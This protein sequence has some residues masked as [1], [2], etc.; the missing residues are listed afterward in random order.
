M[1]ATDKQTFDLDKMLGCRNAPIF[2]QNGKYLI[3]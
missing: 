2:N 3:I 1:T